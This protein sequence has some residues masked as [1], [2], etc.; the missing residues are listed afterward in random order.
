MEKENN[1]IPIYNIHN[2]VKNHQYNQHQQQ[3]QHN[4]NNHQL[5]YNI[6][7]NNHNNNG[8]RIP[9][10]SI[11]QTLLRSNNMNTISTDIY[12]P[13]IDIDDNS[14]SQTSLQTSS[15]KTE[16]AKWTHH[17]DEILKQAVKTHDYKNWRKVAEHLPGKTE[18]QC[19][20]RW[21]KVLNPELTKG[22]WTEEED[23]KVRR[24]VAEYGPKKWS[25]IA[26]ELPGRIGKQCRERWHNHLNPDINKK[27]WTIEEDRQIIISHGTLGNKWAEIAKTLE[28]RTDN[29]IKNHWN[30]SMKRKVEIY[31]KQTYGEDRAIPDT[32]DGHYTFYERDVPAML[33]CIREKSK[34]NQKEKPKTNNSNT[35]QKNPNGRINSYTNKDNSYNYGDS[36][37]DDDDELEEEE[38]EDV[39]SQSYISN[40]KSHSYDSNNENI[41][42][43][44]F[45][46]D[47]NDSN[48]TL[49]SQMNSFDPFIQNNSS[50]S[51]LSI[52]S[53]T[54]VPTT[55]SSSSESKTNVVRRKRKPLDAK[56]VNPL[57]PNISPVAVKDDIIINNNNNNN[58]TK[59]KTNKNGINN[60][61]NSNENGN[62]KTTG[63]K[64]NGSSKN[65]SV[66]Y[67]EDSIIGGDSHIKESIKEKKTR[68]RKS[69]RNIVGATPEKTRS[70]KQRH[71][72]E[73]H[74]ANDWHSTS[75][76][77]SNISMNSAT[78]TPGMDGLRFDDEMTGVG[79]A[80]ALETLKSI[81]LNTPAKTPDL[82]NIFSPDYLSSA[83]KSIKSWGY[84]YGL[85]PIP[86]TPNAISPFNLS[87]GI[88]SPLNTSSLQPNPHDGIVQ[89][90]LTMS[91]QKRKPNKANLEP[92]SIFQELNSSVNLPP[93]N[94]NRSISQLSH[95]SNSSIKNYQNDDSLID[96]DE[97]DEI[98]NGNGNGN[99]NNDSY[100]SS[101]NN[102]Y[103]N[104]NEFHHNKSRRGS[105]SNRLPH[106]EEDQFSRLATNSDNYQNNLDNEIPNSPQSSRSPQLSL[107]ANK[108]KRN[109]EMM[110]TTSTSRMTTRFR[111]KSSNNNNLDNYNN[112][113]TTIENPTSLLS[114]SLDESALTE[115]DNSF[116]NH[117]PQNQPNIEFDIL[118]SP[119]P[120][121]NASS[122]N[123]YQTRYQPNIVIE[124][125][126]VKNDLSFST[127]KEDD[128]NSNSINTLK[129]FTS[130]QGF[131][132][133][134]SIE[135]QNEI[136]YALSFLNSPGVIQ[137]NNSNNNNQHSSIRSTQQQPQH[138]LINNYSFNSPVKGYP[139]Q[140]RLFDNN[141]NNNLNYDIGNNNTTTTTTNIN[142]N[143]NSNNNNRYF[144]DLCDPI[145]KEVDNNGAMALLLLKSPSASI[146]S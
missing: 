141:I 4:N 26:A 109:A 124:S 95:D 35:N 22:P 145:E 23:Q 24:L 103:D 36:E 88:T 9:L 10:P 60:N 114:H 99:N 72:D 56:S 86:S 110:S 62:K 139:T 129:E 41:S 107:S 104:D 69:N 46:H 140:L 92:D 94:S 76:D 74:D 71:I 137:T 42:N 39:L 101:Y 87:S 98:E 126:D 33:Q 44:N 84:D 115:N 146:P 7:L 63:K 53:N 73:S 47:F 68:G 144:S 123:I 18:V 111:I 30:S 67:D 142:N 15:K 43:P 37:S 13:D 135:E 143:N 27:P 52:S 20:H 64:K 61:N 122:P 65:I 136:C 16:K 29:A 50:L 25:K 19:L 97:D 105:Y 59:N 38:P 125:S 130:Q 21:T 128:D 48:S 79:A 2:H 134:P 77:A 55:L 3:H 132:D 91:S 131:S 108:K 28:G 119:I 112:S 82:H 133:F 75:F 100:N 58:T 78:G 118:S 113:I 14:D 31:L 116:C 54:T 5:N 106:Y 93:S 66:G 83:I 96:D 57:L 1:L 51:N 127:D 89:L 11:N 117:L 102:S 138:S 32:A 49:T 85:T 70:K 80:H 17:E 45:S 12:E 6:P 34:K 121:N 8:Q 81:T 90:L 40:Y 120:K